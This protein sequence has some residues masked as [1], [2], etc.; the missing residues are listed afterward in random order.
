MHCKGLGVAIGAA[1]QLV[2]E[3]SCL[4]WA[5]IFD[6][7]VKSGISPCWV[8]NIRTK[9]ILVSIVK[10]NFYCGFAV[11]KYPVALDELDASYTLGLNYYKPAELRQNCDH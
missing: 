5:G 9:L 3:C 4:R 7:A 10:P 8:L 1:L 2:S 11:Y 6:S